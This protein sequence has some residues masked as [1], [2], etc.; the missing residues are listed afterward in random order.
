MQ[1][2]AII[3]ARRQR[4]LREMEYAAQRAH[5]D[6]TGRRETLSLRYQ[7]SFAPTANGN[8]QLSFGALG[9]DLHRD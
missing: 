6:L 5:L 4:F 7:P 9:L 8:G 2:G 3:L 1:A